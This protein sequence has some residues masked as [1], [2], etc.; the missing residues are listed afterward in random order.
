MATSHLICL[1][2]SRR[3]DAVEDASVHLIVT[4]PPYW[5]LKD[6]GDPRQIGFNDSYEDYI[7]NLN[8]VWSECVRALHPGCRVCVNIGDQFA[9]SVYYGRYKVV[10][11]HTEITKFFESAGLDYMGAVIWRKVTT[12]N[13]TGGG[14]VMGSYPH[15]RNG[16]LKLDYEFVLTFK[17]PGKAPTPSP[18]VKKRSALTAA[19]WSDYFSG[20]WSF[21]GERRGLSGEAPDSHL[22]PF[23]E[24]LPRRL[25]RMFTFEGETVLDPFLGSGTTS[26]AALKLGRSS[27]GY[28]LRESYLPLIMRRLRGTLSS[29]DAR[30]ELVRQKP[31]RMSV[32]EE[33]QKLPYVFRDPLRLR[34]RV[35]PRLQS[36]GSNVDGRPPERPE[37]ISVRKVL[38]PT[39]LLLADG[40]EVAL[41]GV[42]TRKGMEADAVRFLS[43]KVVGARI[44]LREDNERTDPSGRRLYYVYLRNKTFLNAH[45]IKRGLAL[46]DRE[47]EHRLSAKFEELERV[48]EGAG[49]WAGGAKK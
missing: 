26:L 13:T 29:F 15:P 20:H 36:Y 35:D 42:R 33:I 14:S 4:S 3:M 9:R 43:E 34:R 31:L 12:C 47:G 17:K 24:E 21:P 8:L 30:I 44:F 39:A 27:M 40:R 23:P 5:Q 28:E 16:I 22:A 6:Y 48:A 45:L 41:L 18:D 49:R 7:N 10:P 37:L 1:G 46:A 2:D 11:I 19:E 38:S 32:E 25:I